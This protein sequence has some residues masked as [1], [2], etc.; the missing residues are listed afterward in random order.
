MPIDMKSDHATEF[1]LRYHRFAPCRQE[2]MVPLKHGFPR[3]NQ[4]DEQAPDAI[5]QT[6]ISG[7]IWAVHLEVITSQSNYFRR[8]IASGFLEAHTKA[9]HMYEV[10]AQ[11]MGFVVEYLYNG[12]DYA[13]TTTFGGWNGDSII[14]KRI[15]EF[16]ILA[17]Y[18]DIPTLC[19]EAYSRIHYKLAALV[20]RARD[21][22]FSHYLCVRRK[23]FDAAI[24]VLLKSKTVLGHTMATRMKGFLSNLVGVNDLSQADKVYREA[25]D[26]DWKYL[27]EEL[28]W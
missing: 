8:A 17:D 13:V 11:L 26:G 15:A 22:Q 7:K 19:Y 10:N 25:F 12:W 27:D 6:G 20:V 3:K 21:V 23:P 2:L 18:L 1:Y 5:I 9:F 24:Q 4:Y 16:M 14:I 28:Q